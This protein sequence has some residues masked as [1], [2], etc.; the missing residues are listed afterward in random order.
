MHAS[1][2]SSIDGLV[3]ALQG[4]HW[5]RLWLLVAKMRARLSWCAAVRGDC[6]SWRFKHVLITQQQFLNCRK[7]WNILIPDFCIHIH[8]LYH[9]PTYDKVVGMT[10]FLSS[11]PPLCFM[12]SLVPFFWPSSSFWCKIRVLLCK[13]DQVGEQ[14]FWRWLWGWLQMESN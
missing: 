6:R 4:T 7:K 14:G 13:K 12:C 11:H 2:R 8:V 9:H 3:L 1:P 10:N 5:E